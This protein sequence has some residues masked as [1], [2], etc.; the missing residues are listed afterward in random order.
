MSKH[1]HNLF[2]AAPLPVAG[3][4]ADERFACLRLIRSENV[5]PV[6]FHALINHFGGTVGVLRPGHHKRFPV[7]VV[8]N[9]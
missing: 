8:S 7:V 6:T 9:L 2:V 3:L 4:D 1:S 5:G